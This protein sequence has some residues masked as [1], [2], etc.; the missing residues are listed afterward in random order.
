M[1]T[2]G[3]RGVTPQPRK[4]RRRRISRRRFY[5]RVTGTVLVAVVLF[6]GTVP[7]L[8]F[9]GLLSNQS[10][11][12]TR[13]WDVV[14][15]APDRRSVVIRVDECSGDFDGASVMRVGR[16]V[17]LTVTIDD[18]SPGT[19]ECVPFPQMPTHVVRFNFMLPA[20]GTV[21]DSGCP[22]VECGDLTRS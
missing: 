6:F 15:L 4:P 12:A 8:H 20:D 10:S 9:F 11:H 7:T 17:R 2:V 22:K 13:Q 18:E 3:Y 19:V 21:I 1:E 16:D 5:R 14:R